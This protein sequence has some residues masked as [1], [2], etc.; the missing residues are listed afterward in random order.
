MVYKWM[1]GSLDRLLPP[2]CLCCQHPG[3]PLCPACCRDL[4]WLGA[5]CQR[6]ALPLPQH[7]R[8]CR[9]CLRRPPR[10]HRCL[11]A[12]C[13]RPPVD[14]LLL[15]YKHARQLANGRVLAQQWLQA[16]GDDARNELP[17]ALVPTPLHWQRRWQRHFNQSRLLAEYWSR[18]LQLPVEDALLRRRRTAPQQG[19]TAAQ[20]R[21]NL[22]R[23]FLFNPRADVAGKHLALV[24]D[25][26]TTGATANAAAAI[27]LDAGA[28]RVDIWCLAR[29]PEPGQ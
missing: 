14:H 3:T 2:R 1:H 25:V 15:H 6:C 18:A 29:T 9:H 7:G 22:R 12:F 17:N 23:A 16:C 19:L 28:Q 26:V 20:R 11:S 4:P 13:Y 27:L 5:H 21:R 24:D 8:L 10:F